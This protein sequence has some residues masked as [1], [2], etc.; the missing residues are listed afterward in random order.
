MNPH[1]LLTIALLWTSEHAKGPPVS[2]DRY[3]QVASDTLEAESFRLHVLNESDSVVV[4]QRVQTSCGCVL[5]TV[6]RSLATRN[7]PGDIYVGYL[8]NKLDALQPVTIDVYTNRNP[9]TPMR[10]YIWKA[11]PKENQ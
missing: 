2:L 9:L 8:T 1:V 11:K 7:E 10:L 5:A 4:I 3:E 6:Q